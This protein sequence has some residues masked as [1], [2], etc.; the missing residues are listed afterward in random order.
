[1][2]D[3]RAQFRSAEAR[4]RRAEWWAGWYLRAK[5]YRVLATRMRTRF[6]EVDLV[7]AQG[8]TL[9]CVEIKQRTDQRTALEM[10]G[11]QT[12]ARVQRAARA[13]AAKYP[14]YPTVR[15]DVVVISGRNWPLHIR[16]VGFDLESS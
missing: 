4:G 16:N 8:D 9:V 12:L 1:M 13:V 7:A 15:I 11:G 5:G 2:T 3:R 6:G 10:L 14:A